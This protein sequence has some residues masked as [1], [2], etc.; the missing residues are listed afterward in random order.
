MARLADWLGALLRC[1]NRGTISP[2]DIHR[3]FASNLSKRLTPM[4][5]I[6]SSLKLGRRPCVAWTPESPHSAY[7]H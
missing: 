6:Q 1:P 4:E 2:H 7:G 3:S 5:V